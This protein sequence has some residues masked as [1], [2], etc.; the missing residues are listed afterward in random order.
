MILADTSVWVRHFR[1]ANLNLTR[2][3]R[4]RRIVTCDVVIGELALGS[5]L[6]AEI[7]DDLLL[8]PRLPTVSAA[9][10]LAFIRRHQRTFSAAG[11][12]WADAQIISTAVESGA[13]LH[14][15]DRPQRQVWRA[16]GFRLAG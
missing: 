2:Q 11:L 16:L 15:A 12:G 1:A 14:S 4:E 10:T 7:E 5:G 8:L 6:P 13:L 3:L 9:E